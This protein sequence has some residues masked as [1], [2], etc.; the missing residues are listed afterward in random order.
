MVD[1][2][3]SV[4]RG[5]RWLLRLLRRRRLRRTARL[6]LLQSDR[7]HAGRGER[8]SALH[9]GLRR[10]I[11]RQ[12]REGVW[13]LLA[14]RVSGGRLLLACLLLL[15]SLLLLLPVLL[16]IPLLHLRGEVRDAT[17][18]VFHTL[19]GLAG[20][21]LGSRAVGRRRV[22]VGRPAAATSAASGRR[23]RVASGRRRLRA[24]VRQLVL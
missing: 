17:L 2:G 10:L 22:A 20:R 19:D 6:L 9:S 13:R 4:H 11:G 3:P 21:G 18:E 5:V 23:L 15:L 8:H 16:A 1:G 12:G 24:A 14:V 7:L